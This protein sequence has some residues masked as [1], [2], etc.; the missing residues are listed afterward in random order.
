VRIS[1]FTCGWV[2]AMRE[3]QNSFKAAFVHITINYA[4]LYVFMQSMYVANLS[5]S[6]SFVALPNC[7]DDDMVRLFQ[8]CGTV[9]RV[10][11]HGSHKLDR[12]IYT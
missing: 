1:Y 12:F 5:T 9:T 7:F 2:Q 8:I 10:F 11:G 4:H 6:M 3:N